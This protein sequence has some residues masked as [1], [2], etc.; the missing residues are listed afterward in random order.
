MSVIG[1]ATGFGQPA[2]TGAATAAPGAS[3]A[4]TDGTP[5][6][7][8]SAR[9][10]PIMI[11]LVNPGP[12]EV[13]GVI[14]AAA[15]M[16]MHA[17]QTSRELTPEEVLKS[18]D[19]ADDLTRSAGLIERRAALLDSLQ[20]GEGDPKELIKQ[21]DGLSV[22]IDVARRQEEKRA[23]MKKL[24]KQLMLGVLTPQMASQAKALGLTKFLKDAIKSL[25]KSGNLMPHELPAIANVLATA[26]IQMPYLDELVI[27]HERSA[28]STVNAA[29]A[30]RGQ[31][32]VAT[33]PTGQSIAGTR[34]VTSGNSAL[35]ELGGPAA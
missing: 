30:A 23:F 28:Q 4:P 27:Q 11:E 21:L 24:M 13:A 19:T 20:R 12:G 32:A 5:S 33:S 34:L 1:A 26:G 15:A 16:G 6:G 14:E 29:R 35:L 25:V 31:E 17:T 3:V 9:P 7:A 10:A 22:L 2:V 8:T 18:I